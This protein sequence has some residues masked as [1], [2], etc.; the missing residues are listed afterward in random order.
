MKTLIFDIDG[1]VLR[2]NS[3]LANFLES[4]GIDKQRFLD[5]IERNEFMDLAT[6]IHK[7]ILHD[8]HRSKYCR[9]LS[10][11][12]AQA[13][14]IMRRLS[15]DY[16]IYALTSFSEHQG[17]IENRIHNLDMHYAGCFTHIEILPTLAPKKEKLKELSAKLDVQYFIDD[18]RLHIEEGIEV[19]GGKKVIWFTSR[20]TPLENKEVTIINTWDS[21]SKL[22]ERPKTK[23]RAKNGPGR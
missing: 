6:E 7:D 14:E 2:W 12:E 20:P 1:V 21:L 16:Q 3:Q 22:L 11:F 17:S 4:V 18:T 13:P 23:N 5:R 9:E 10:P 19:L 8:Y 15:K